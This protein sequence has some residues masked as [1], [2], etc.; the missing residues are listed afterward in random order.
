MSTRD[1]LATVRRWTWDPRPA[2]AAGALLIAGGAAATAL[3][4]PPS[5]A[6][7]RPLIVGVIL[8]L[9]GLALPVL[10]RR[11]RQRSGG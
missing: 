9:R 10:L 11:R 2:I 8:V 5:H 4:W 3:T 7:M 6:S 1:A